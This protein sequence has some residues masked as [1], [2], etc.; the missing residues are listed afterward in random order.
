MAK[1]KVLEINFEKFKASIHWLNEFKR[2]YK[3]VSRKVTKVI[4]KTSIDDSE[5]RLEQQQE[6]RNKVKNAIKKYDD[7]RVYNSDQSGFKYEIH[8][9]R[10]LN[11]KGDTNVEC[12]VQSA[13]STTHSYTIQPTVSAEG[14]LLSPMFLVL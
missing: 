1:E 6:F 11:T 12:I 5:E 2:R 8:S 7:K 13:H 14:K 10:T 9:G 3:I 4:S